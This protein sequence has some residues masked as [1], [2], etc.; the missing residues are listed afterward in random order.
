M[1]STG[2]TAPGPDPGPDPPRTDALTPLDAGEP[3]EILVVNW[4]DRE[5]PR[6]GG[7]ETHLHETFGR[8]ARA[9]HRV[10]LLCSGWAGAPARAE[11]DGIQ[12]HRVGRRYTFS[13]HVAS[14]ARRHLERPHVLVEDLNKVPVFSPLW[15][16]APVALLVHHLFGPTAFQEAN[17]VLAGA[18]WLLERPLPRLYRD[19]PTLAVSESTRDDLVERGMPRHRI[20]VVPNGIDP[21]A[22][23]PDPD[24]PVEEFSRPTLLFVGRLKRYKR[25]DL[26]IRAVAR[27]AREGLDAE[28]RIAGR[29]DHRPALERL[30]RELEVAD[31]VRFEGFV[32]HD[33]KVELLR[34]SWVH[35]LTSPKEGWGITNLEA[36]AAGTPTV[37]SDAPGL[38]ESVLH[39]ETGLL[40]PHGDLDAL[41]EALTQLLTDPGER[42]TMGRKAR[43]FAGTFSWDT[44]ARRTLA[45]LRDAAGRKNDRSEGTR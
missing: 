3:L 7:A 39:A 35:V 40:V 12:V 42:S 25:V 34:R 18:T 28:L 9:G 15:S 45:F 24:R 1:P 13:L 5:N 36:A 20:R 19:I 23:A 4:L 22:F 27:L 43:T 32:S 10:T 26:V 8:V 38:R 29:G 41:V 33:R 11:L 31:R 2:V 14:Y 37:A 44:T 17:P 6:S 21:T 16:R 30:T